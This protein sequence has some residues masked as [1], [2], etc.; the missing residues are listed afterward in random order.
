MQTITKECHKG[1]FLTDKLDI[2]TRN[3]I[4]N[5]QRHYITKK[6]NSQIKNFKLYKWIEL[7]LEIQKR[8][9]ITENVNTPLLVIGIPN[10]ENICKNIEDLNNALNQLLTFIPY[11]F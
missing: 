1:N 3:V 2:R 7:K 6:I 8:T 9:I 4:R 5:E 11:S 10:K